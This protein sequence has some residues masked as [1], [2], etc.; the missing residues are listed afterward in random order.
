MPKTRYF[1][2]PAKRTLADYLKPRICAVRECIAA[3]KGPTLPQLTYQPP[4]PLIEAPAAL[5]GC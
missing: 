4:G 3:R 1:G 5:P 2:T